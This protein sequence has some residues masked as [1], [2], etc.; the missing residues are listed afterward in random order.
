M[1]IYFATHY[2]LEILINNKTIKEF[3]ETPFTWQ[4]YWNYNL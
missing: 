4:P 1:K 2:A 3:L